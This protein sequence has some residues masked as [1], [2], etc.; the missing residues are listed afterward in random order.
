MH[1]PP[2]RLTRYWIPSVIGYLAG[3]AVIRFMSGRQ[4]DILEWLG[5]LG[6][7]ARDFA[8]NWIWEPVLHV[9]DTI[10]LKDER[11][12]VLGEEGLQND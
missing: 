2:S 9:W 12:S 11:L 10:R 5:D 3:N 7:T 6:I 1:G 8:F 4:H